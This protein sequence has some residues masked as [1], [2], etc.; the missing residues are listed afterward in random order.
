MSDWLHSLPIVWMAA[1]IFLATYVV[2][3]A[4]YW[5]ILRLAVGERVRG[6]KA[7]SP[8]LLPPLGII[9]GLLVAF[10]ASQAW[11]MTPPGD[12]G[13]DGSD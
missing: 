7:V 13:S 10:Q 3:F 5:I 12:A 11:G 6:F 4:I 9:F 8:G 1:V 2:T